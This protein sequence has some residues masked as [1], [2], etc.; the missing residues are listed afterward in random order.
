M[1]AG[2]GG[3]AVTEVGRDLERCS[4]NGAQGTHTALLLR[5]VRAV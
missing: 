1:D 5:L 4:D 2:V 3:A